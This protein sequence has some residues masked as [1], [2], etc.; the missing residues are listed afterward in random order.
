M[1][2]VVSHHDSLLLKKRLFK[3]RLI[4]TSVEESSQREAMSRCGTT[5]TRPRT[6]T[7]VQ[8]TGIATYDTRSKPR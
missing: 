6:I 2:I 1:R 3:R 5:S 4:A 7:E 8:L